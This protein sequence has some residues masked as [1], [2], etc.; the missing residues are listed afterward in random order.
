VIFAGWIVEWGGSLKWF[1]KRLGMEIIL[2]FE[3]MFG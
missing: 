2:T 1:V 3:K